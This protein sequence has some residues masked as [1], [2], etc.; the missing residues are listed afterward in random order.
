MTIRTAAEEDYEQIASLYSNFFTTHNIF[1]KVTELVV[2]YIKEEAE[3]H[4]LLVYEEGGLI[5]GALFLVGL[6]IEK[7][8]KRWK[9]RHFAFETEKVAKELLAEAEKKIKESSRTAKVELTIAESEEGIEFY[10][11]NGYLQE[12]MLKNHYRWG[13]SCFVLGKSFG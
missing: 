1:Q 7:G 13:E 12:G 11:Q 10:K 4:E 8:H 6:R 2:K 9:F 5:K 3:K